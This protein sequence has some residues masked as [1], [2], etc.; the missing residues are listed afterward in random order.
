MNDFVHKLQLL[1]QAETTIL[2]I[3]LRTA[4]RQ[5]VLYAI[6]IVL[7]LLAVAMLN[8]ALYVALSDA[9]GSSMG[10]LIVAAVNGM[11]A[12]TLLVMA[13]RARHG[14]EMTHAEEVRDLVIQGIH[15]DAQK[16]AKS[17]DEVKFSLQRIHSGLNGLMGGGG[18][19][20]GLLHLGPLLD[21]LISSLSR[22]D[23]AS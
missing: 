22:S 15:A 1:K 10:A 9:M 12:A 17:L 13:G 6:G 3:H 7:I 11:L 2:R 23:K 4:A 8:V 20:L 5:A 21:L 16:A 18:S 14:S 19:M